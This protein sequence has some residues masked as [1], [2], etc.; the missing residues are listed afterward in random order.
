MSMANTRRSDE[1]LSLF[2]KV[3]G[4]FISQPGWPDRENLAQTLGTTSE[5]ISGWLSDRSIPS[6]DQLRCI[7]EIADA[8]PLRSQ[9]DERVSR[10]FAKM[11]QTRA[12]QISPH[13]EQMLPTVGHYLMKPDIQR[14]SNLLDAL[15]PNAQEEVLFRAAERVRHF[16]DI[17]DGRV[18]PTEPADTNYGTVGRFLSRFEA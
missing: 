11:T 15:P 5:E 14:F 1:Q 17:E 18:Q 12:S 2:A 13:G 16:R 3:L 10:S 7:V 4:A 9:L 6:P 8:E